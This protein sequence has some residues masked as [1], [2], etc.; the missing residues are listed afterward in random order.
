MKEL[1]F[2]E[3]LANLEKIVTELE[4]GDVSLD[5]AINKYTEAMK[6]SKICSDKLK[7]AEEQI[8]KI[9]K[10]SGTLENFEVE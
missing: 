10:D 9:V 7:N 2:E 1:S 5:A 8:N 4:S 3:Q 6:I